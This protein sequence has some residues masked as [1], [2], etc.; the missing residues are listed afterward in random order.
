MVGK[1]QGRICHPDR[2]EKPAL[3]LEEILRCAQDDTCVQDDRRENTE[4]VFCPPVTCWLLLL[5]A[6]ML[7]L[8]PGCG[9]KGPKLVP[10]SGVVTVDEKPLRGGFVRVVPES[11]RPSGGTIGTDGRFMLGCFTKNDGCITGN[12]RI[13]VSGFVNLSETERKWLAPRKYASTG[14]SGLTATIDG[15][16]DALK[17]DLTWS[18]TPETGPFVE[19][20]PSE[21]RSGKGRG[22]QGSQ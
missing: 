18:G 22:S 5:A 9:Q 7:I 10:V 6:G 21:F 13:E 2:S 4:F 3:K 19:T 11:G 12:H 8:T 17:I 16:T 14:T 1:R 20:L 15:P